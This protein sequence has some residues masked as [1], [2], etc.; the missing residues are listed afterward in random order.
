MELGDSVSSFNH[1]YTAEM[2][3]ASWK[4]TRS[5]I[6]W[7][8]NYC[9]DGKYM[10]HDWRGQTME[11]TGFQ[12]KTFTNDSQPYRI[13]V[14]LLHNVPKRDDLRAIFESEFF[15]ICP[16]EQTFLGKYL[17]Y[18]TDYMNSFICQYAVSLFC[19]TI[20]SPV[21]RQSEKHIYNFYMQRKAL[22][23]RLGVEHGI[24]HTEK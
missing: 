7:E 20:N 15:S 24:E 5:T 1:A 10:V 19:S 12:K 13:G 3:H 16:V 17:T 14:S 4:G 18:T 22:N 2:C 11:A 21:V 23:R 9:G 6:K 8:Q